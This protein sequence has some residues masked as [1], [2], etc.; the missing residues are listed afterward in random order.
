MS[1]SV[2]RNSLACVADERTYEKAA[3]QKL[4]VFQVGHPHLRNVERE[5]DRQMTI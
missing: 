2:A 5:H 1:L 3:V 4:I